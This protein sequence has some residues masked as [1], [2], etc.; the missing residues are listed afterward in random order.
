[1]SVGRIQSCCLAAL[2]LSLTVGSAAF[3]A[4]TAFIDTDDPTGAP[5][6]LRLPPGHTYRFNVDPAQSQ[7]VVT[8]EVMGRDD[9]DVS[10]V[11]GWL[12]V[13][14]AP[15]QAPFSTIHVTDLDLQLAEQIDL[16]YGLLGSATGT[17]IG[18]DMN[19]PGSA[20]AVETDDSF[21]QMNNYLA[22]R[23]LFEYSFILIGSGSVDLATMDPVAS[24]L[25]GLVWQDWTTI[26]VQMNIDIEYPLEVD[27]S[28]VGTA[29]IQ[30]TI[31]ATAE[32]FWAVAD[33]YSD[34]LVNFRDFAVFAAAWDTSLGQPNYNAD[35][36]LFDPPGGVINAMDLAVVADHWL[37]AVE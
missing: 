6:I 2:I 16:S 33:L 9:S 14:L 26:T 3:A 28:A 13:T 37:A 10:P 15:G 34:G 31:I 29:W 21:I 18:V 7:I 35:C 27:G 24:D 17:G 8:A 22:A 25:A 11:A 36:D 32:V 20:A 1:M 5:G 30:G 12:D 4:E 19:E 23:G